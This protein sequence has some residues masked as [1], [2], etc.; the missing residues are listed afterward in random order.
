MFEPIGDITLRKPPN[1]ITKQKTNLEVETY[2]IA[3]TMEE[4]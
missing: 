2:V 3:T 1:P 4:V